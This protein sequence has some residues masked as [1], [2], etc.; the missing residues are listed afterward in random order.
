MQRNNLLFKY[1]HTVKEE[2]LPSFSRAGIKSEQG[3]VHGRFLRSCSVTWV[4]KDNKLQKVAEIPHK[5]EGS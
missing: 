3:L 1:V 2:N 4:E 5:A